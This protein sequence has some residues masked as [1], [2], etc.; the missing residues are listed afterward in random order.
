MQFHKLRS[1]ILA[2]T[3][4]ALASLGAMSPANADLLYR[5][6]TAD[7]ATGI[8]AWTEANFGVSGGGGVPGAGTLSFF[9]YADDNT[10]RAQ[11]PAA[12]CFVRIDLVNTHNAQPGANAPV[13]NNGIAVGA[14]AADQ[15]RPF[16]W[17][18]NFDNNPPGHWSIARA[19]IT[20]RVS[21]NVASRVARFGFFNL[22]TN[23]GSNVT[24]INGTLNNCAAQ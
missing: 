1:R 18:V 24:V 20:D 12:Q 21:N 10:A 2:A 15:P 19:E 22:A 7:A 9:R 3:L 5:A 6:V 17:T 11:M 4:A 14:P 23:A 8:V 13:G 16:P